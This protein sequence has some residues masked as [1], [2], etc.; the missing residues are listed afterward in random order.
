VRGWSKLE[1]YT[2]CRLSTVPGS[3]IT[4]LQIPFIHT[5]VCVHHTLYIHVISAIYLQSRVYNPQLTW[6]SFPTYSIIPTGVQTTKYFWP[7]N[8]T[9]LS[10][11]CHWV[12]FEDFTVKQRLSK[13]PCDSHLILHI[14]QDIKKVSLQ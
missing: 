9:A 2:D 12:G 10:L 14:P 5:E 1:C 7:Q 8:K 11:P 3:D 13:E 6:A 4:I